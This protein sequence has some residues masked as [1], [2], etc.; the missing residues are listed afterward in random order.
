MTS[1]PCNF[2]DTMPFSRTLSLFFVSFTCVW[3]L[4]LS[5]SPATAQS[6]STASSN[7]P[8]RI[9]FGLHLRPILSEHC[10]HC[11]GPDAAHRQADLRLD[12]ET[13]ARSV[14]IPGNSLQSGL[15]HRITSD[16]P[17]QVMPPPSA[18]KTVTQEQKNLLKRWIDE[19][20][21]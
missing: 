2:D 1:A 9:D 14:I 19:G 12:D 5:A 18:R 15:W 11:H 16:D 13:V 8:S 6:S 21:A 10:F 7:N 4:A 17:D 3:Q 20:A